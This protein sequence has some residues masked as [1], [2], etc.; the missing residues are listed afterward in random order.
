MAAHSLDNLLKLW[1]LH[2]LSSEQAIGQILQILIALEPRVARLEKTFATPTAPAP[3][4]VVSLPPPPLEPP[5]V[6]ISP[7]KRSARRKG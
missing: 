5:A 3:A 2:Q 6:S 7:R 1:A 4:A